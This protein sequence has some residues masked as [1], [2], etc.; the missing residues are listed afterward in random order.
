LSSIGSK[1]LSPLG[2]QKAHEQG[3]GDLWTLLPSLLSSKE[4]ESPEAPVPLLAAGNPELFL[5]LG[6]FAPRSDLVPAN[7]YRW[8]YLENPW[9]TQQEDPRMPGTHMLV[10]RTAPGS[11]LTNWAADLGRDAIDLVVE[12]ARR[13]TNLSAAGVREGIL[14]FSAD[15]PSR[16]L[17]GSRYWP[18]GASS[19][20]KLDVLISDDKGF[21]ATGA[22]WDGEL[23]NFTSAG[24]GCKVRS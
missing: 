20:M 3:K 8:I 18:G 14:S 5:E 15:D 9:M 11:N 19:P 13:T 7:G 23:R 21:C 17:T 16:G 24:S 6:L 12:A 1:G 22:F 2:W 4:N 10:P